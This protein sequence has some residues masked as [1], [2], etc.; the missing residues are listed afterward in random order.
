MQQGGES[1]SVPD[2]EDFNQFTG[3]IKLKL[4]IQLSGIPAT[5]ASTDSTA[6]AIG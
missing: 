1:G 2:I 5:V 6:A 3:L 4:A